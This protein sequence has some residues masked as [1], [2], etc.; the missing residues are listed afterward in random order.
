MKTQRGVGKHGHH[1]R[2]T[3]DTARELGFQVTKTGG[4]YLARH[5]KGGPPVYFPSTS[6]SVSG[7]RNCIA[8]LRRIVRALPA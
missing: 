6:R 5:P 3:L 8:L 2:L 7:Q 1:A 4:H